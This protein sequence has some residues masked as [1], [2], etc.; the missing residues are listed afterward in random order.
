MPRAAQAL[1]QRH[2]K[3][4]E[5]VIPMSFMAQALAHKHRNAPE[6]EIPMHS[7]QKCHSGRHRKQE[8]PAFPMLGPRK[9]RLEGI[10]NYEIRKKK[11]HNAKTGR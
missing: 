10:G 11:C 9:S 5:F 4:P 2:R 1:A 3:A 8:I 6:F 7:H